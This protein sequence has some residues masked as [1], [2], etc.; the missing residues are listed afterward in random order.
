MREHLL[1]NQT[2]ISY[3]YGKDNIDDIKNILYSM[4]NNSDKS[5]LI[6]YPETVIPELYKK[7]KIFI[8]KYYLEIQNILI[9]GI[10]RYDLDSNKTFNSMLIIENREL[11]YDKIKLVPFGEFTPLQELFTPLARL[12]NIPMSNLSRG[13][14]N[15]RDNAKNFM[16]YPLI[17]YESTY[18][19]LIKQKNLSKPG[20][21]VILSNDSWFGDSLA[22]YQHL[23]ISQTRAV[24]FNKYICLELPTLAYQLLL[25]I[26]EKLEG[27]SCIKSERSVE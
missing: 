2:L 19:R 1:Y 13:N 26:T 3:K 22:P 14:T 21:I 4:S 20:V 11:F 10:F 18:P 5:D 15:Q 6:I 9:S 7:R 16:I 25:T 23:Q 8:I 17:C 27:E 12:L 24:E